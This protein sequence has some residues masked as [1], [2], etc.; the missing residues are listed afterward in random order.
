[1]VATFVLFR[2]FSVFALFFGNTLLAQAAP[3]GSY[4]NARDSL[5]VLDSRIPLDLAKRSGCFVRG[6]FS[7]CLRE[8]TSEGEVIDVAP[9]LDVRVVE[10]VEV[11]PSE[12]SSKDKRSGCF[13]RGFFDGCLREDS[14]DSVEEEPAAPP[15]APVDM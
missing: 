9:E 7:G 6:D 2:T 11:A 8:D 12:E 4:G 3:V 14:A 13:M 10:P 1:M 15:E 5:L